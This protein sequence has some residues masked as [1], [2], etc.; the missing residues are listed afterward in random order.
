MRGMFSNS[1]D[2]SWLLVINSSEWRE[3]VIVNASLNSD[4]LKFIDSIVNLEFYFH[5]I[6]FVTLRF[7]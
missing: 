4:F 2:V 1:R 5:F 6:F 3:L 7:A